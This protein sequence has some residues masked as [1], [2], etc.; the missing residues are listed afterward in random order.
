M[1]RLLAWATFALASST[2]AAPTTPF[3]AWR[4]SGEEAQAR[5]C[6]QLK[7]M[8]VQANTTGQ[9]YVAG[10]RAASLRLTKFEQI[11]WLW[12]MSAGSHHLIAYES[13]HQA[14]VS[15]SG[16]L[17]RFSADLMKRH[18]CTR[19]PAFNVVASMSSV[20][21]VFLAGIGTVAEVDI[22]SGRYLWRVR[23]LYER[24]DAFN[25]FMTGVERGHMVEFYAVAGGSSSTPWMALV[26][27]ATGKLRS[28]N[29]VESIG[30]EAFA[31]P[32][33]T[34]PCLR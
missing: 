3:S 33:S 7:G 12:S 6:A 10:Q 24:S 23:G 2:C 11:D 9:L 18:W 13:T 26:D 22:R 25:S 15:S 17:C 31:L 28:V 4:K 34:G 27:R 19:F 1:N 29:A 5:F 14:D 16:G 21:T 32:R 8:D 20:G 30:S